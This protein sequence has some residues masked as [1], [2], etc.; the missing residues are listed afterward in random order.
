MKDIS[1]ATNPALRGSLA[2]LRRAAEEARRIAIQTGTD[3]IVFRNGE[4]TRIPPQELAEPATPSSAPEV[5]LKGLSEDA[6]QSC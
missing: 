4:I 3:L 1:E 6:D 5:P 2:A